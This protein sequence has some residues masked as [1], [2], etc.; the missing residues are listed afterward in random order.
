MNGEGYGRDEVEPRR[1]LPGDQP[2]LSGPGVK[3]VSALGAGGL[4][5]LGKPW[6]P[7]LLSDNIDYAIS[8]RFQRNAFLF[9][10]T[11]AIID[12]GHS[13]LHMVQH[14]HFDGLISRAEPDIAI[15]SR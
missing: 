13:T 9:R 2:P 6:V 8:P 3:T 10:V 14:P 4:K 12:F 7:A 5:R 11:K 15:W 1:D